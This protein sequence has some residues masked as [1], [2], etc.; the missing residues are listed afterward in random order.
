M[1]IYNVWNPTNDDNP[2]SF[3]AVDAESAAE[4][5]AAD[6]WHREPWEGDELE[7]LVDGVKHRVVADFEPTF[8]A[9][10]RWR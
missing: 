3:D 6:D 1:A 2:R 4:Q 9:A 7:V 10:S 5:Y 8:C